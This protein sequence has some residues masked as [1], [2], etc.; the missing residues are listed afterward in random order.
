[1]GRIMGGRITGI[2]GRITGRI[3]IGVAAAMEGTAGTR[4]GEAGGAGVACGTGAAASD[5]I[6]RLGGSGLLG[7]EKVDV[8]ME[9][10]GGAGEVA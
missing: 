7:A 3:L 6:G 10:A 1:M 8:I 9:G 5:T 4:I 2:T